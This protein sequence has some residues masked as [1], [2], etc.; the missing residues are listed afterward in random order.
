MPTTSSPRAEPAVSFD[1]IR[2]IAIADVPVGWRRV[3][4]LMF[5]VA[6]MSFFIGLAPALM[7]LA[8]SWCL[9]GATYIMCRKVAA[10][11]DQWRRAY[12]IVALALPWS[13]IIYSIL[14]WFTGV[15][16]AKIFSLCSLF[17]TATYPVLSNY[18]DKRLLTGLILPPLIT[19]FLMMASLVVTTMP[20]WVIPFA[21]LS[22]LGMNA[23]IIEAATIMHGVNRDLRTAQGA[24][25]A[26]RDA[27]DQRVF[28]VALE[29]LQLE[30][31]PA[32]QARQPFFDL[33][34][35]AG[36]VDFRLARAEQVEI[37]AVNY[38]NA[39]HGDRLRYRRLRKVRDVNQNWG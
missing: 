7:W 19:L 8:A 34:Q 5:G 39:A 9:E 3:P 25:Q 36:A 13:W 16:A 30:A 27:L 33:A 38:Q 37:G 28:R 35:G 14:L 18:H 2:Q 26:E 20:W 23:V 17:A 1:G 10:G 24:L 4:L 12:I 29:A 6:P 15:E 22:A 31:T 32:G 21:M 11:E